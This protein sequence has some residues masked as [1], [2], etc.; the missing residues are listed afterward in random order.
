M[1]TTEAIAELNKVA[2][3]YREMAKRQASEFQG[4]VDRMSAAHSKQLDELFRDWGWSDL[5]WRV[6]ALVEFAMI[7]VLAVL[8]R[9]K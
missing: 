5:R 8:W 6:L 1:N 4:V 2:D 9:M 7:V 3:E